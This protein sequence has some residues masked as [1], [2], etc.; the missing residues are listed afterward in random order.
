MEKI[1]DLPKE[2]PSN[3]MLKNWAKRIASGEAQAIPVFVGG[4]WSLQIQRG[5]KR[6]ITL[7]LGAAKN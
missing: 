5:K 3:R 1:T 2:K 6:R 7:N 4:E